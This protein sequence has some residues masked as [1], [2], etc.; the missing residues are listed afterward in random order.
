[1]NRSSFGSLMRGGPGK[2]KKIKKREV[3]MKKKK[4]KKKGY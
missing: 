1:M 3:T 4:G 2:R